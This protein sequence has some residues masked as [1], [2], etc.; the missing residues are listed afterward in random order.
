MRTKQQNDAFH[1]GMESAWESGIT[2][3]T[4]PDLLAHFLAGQ[5]EG[6]ACRET[7]DAD[8]EFID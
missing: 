6:E 3:P 1:L 8:M 2:P 7:Y 5:D 4:G